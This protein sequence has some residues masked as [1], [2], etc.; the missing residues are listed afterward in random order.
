MPDDAR[1]RHLHFVAKH[2]DGARRN[3]A[4]EQAC[5]DFIAHWDDDDWHAPHPMAYQI[6]A[7]RAPSPTLAAE[8]EGG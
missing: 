2:T 8:R 7:R 5:G 1:V 3:I 4:C 6:E